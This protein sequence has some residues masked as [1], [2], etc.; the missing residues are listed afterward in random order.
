MRM[1]LG[2]EL[3]M[4]QVSVF[5]LFWTNLAPTCP[6]SSDG[7]LSPPPP[8]LA[9]WSDASS[10]CLR[11]QQ[12]SR[13]PCVRHWG[14]YLPRGERG[15]DKIRKTI[16]YIA[17]SNLLN[18]R[19]TVIVSFFTCLPCVW[20]CR[21][22]FLGP[23]LGWWIGQTSA[24]SSDCRN[25]CFSS[26]L[27]PQDNAAGRRPHGEGHPPPHCPPNQHPLK[28]WQKRFWYKSSKLL[29]VTKCFTRTKFHPTGRWK[30]TWAEK[31]E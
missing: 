9:F 18:G 17:A 2:T 28:Q 4:E 12:M 31:R 26:E 5:T 24:G 8:P 23:A 14:T 19:L 20:H 1:N 21:W 22:P 10:L 27:F 7:S 13:A 3:T 29:T 30:E 16:H 11:P 15:T 6:P 25:L